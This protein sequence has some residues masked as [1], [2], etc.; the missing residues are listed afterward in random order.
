[1]LF[2]LALGWQREDRKVEVKLGAMFGPRLSD[3]HQR[4]SVTDF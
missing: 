2:F 4:N 3:R 1:M